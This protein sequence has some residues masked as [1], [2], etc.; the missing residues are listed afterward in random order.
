MKRQLCLIIAVTATWGLAAG[1]TIAP[2]NNCWQ[3]FDST[4]VA[5]GTGVLT[6]PYWVNQSQ[7]G[8]AQGLAFKLGQYS[9]LQYQSSGNAPPNDTPQNFYFLNSTAERLQAQFLL[10]VTLD[11]LEFGWYDVNGPSVLNPLFTR[12]GA[13]NAT[14]ITPPSGIVEFSPS[15]Q[16][17]FYLKYLNVP[18]PGPICA[19]LVTAGATQVT[20][21]ASD[22]FTQAPLLKTNQVVYTQS[23]LNQGGPLSE[24]AFESVATIPGALAPYHQHFVALMSSNAA[25]NGSY[26]VGMDDIFGRDPVRDMFY[27]VYE[28]NG[29]YQDFAVVISP[30]AAPEPST[31]A[32]IG[33][34]LAGL[35]A[36]RRRS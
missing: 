11:N 16:F 18:I 26:V 27:G 25:H 2:C 5:D 17:G 4:Q 12:T 28:G 13:P 29:D 30:L 32:L 24:A 21:Q 6:N 34:G 7:D 14:V 1:T 19:A 33:L 31:F 36:F 10:G 3:S 8:A 20:A 22:C 9:P 23:S 35:A 15:A